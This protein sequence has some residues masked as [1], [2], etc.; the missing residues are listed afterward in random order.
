MLLLRSLAV[1][2]G[3]QLLALLVLLGERRGRG[4]AVAGVL[5]G[6]I[7]AGSLLVRSLDPGLLLGS[8]VLAGGL[9]GRSV[10]HGARVWRAA[11]AGLL[12]FL[13]AATLGLA[14]SDPQRAWSD[15]Q[16]QMQALTEPQPAA[17]AAPRGPEEQALEAEYRALAQ[18]A[19]TWTMRLLPAEIVVFGLVQVLVIVVLAG[20]LVREA[21]RPVAVL[22]VSAWRLP[23][24]IVWVLA[25][26]LGLACMRQ[27]ALVD[28]G[29]NV[30]LVGVVLLSVQGLAVLLAF[31]ERTLTGPARWAVLG[32]AAL[33]PLPFTVAGTALLGM[34]DLWV[35]FRRP[36]PAVNDS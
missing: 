4:P 24:G 2:A 16:A 32:L 8:G 29:L 19:T 30:V 1:L 25:G 6:V 28:A 23:F 13:A 22:P 11:L 36:R 3:F 21:G 26:G 14:A 20:R 35:D 9:V 33:A 12:P 10:R 27:R 18:R 31:L 34:A 17:R 5:L 15:L 7:V